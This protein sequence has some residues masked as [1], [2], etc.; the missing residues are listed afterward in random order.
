MSTVGLTMPVV[1]AIGLFT[2]QDVV[3]A[4]YPTNLALLGISVVLTAVTALT[5]KVT[6]FH[7]AGHRGGLCAVYSD[8]VSLIASEQTTLNH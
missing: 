4:E 5:P 7:G 6:A 2:G 1:L 3:L 8:R